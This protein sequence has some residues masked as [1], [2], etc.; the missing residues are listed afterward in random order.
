MSLCQEEVTGRR[1]HI[2]FPPELQYQ[3]VDKCMY[4]CKKQAERIN[5]SVLA[6]IGN[7]TEKPVILV[8]L[9]ETGSQFISS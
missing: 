2:S 7:E 3:N 5:T 1:L 4:V 9:T 6:M 8:Y